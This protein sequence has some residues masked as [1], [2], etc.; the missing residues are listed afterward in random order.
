MKN[1]AQASRGHTVPRLNCRYGKD[2]A[3]KFRCCLTRKIDQA[4]FFKFCGEVTAYLEGVARTLSKKSG[5][6]NTQIKFYLGKEG[7]TEL[8]PS[9]RVSAADNLEE[10]AILRQSLEAAW[11]EGRKQLGLTHL[12]E[13]EIA[14]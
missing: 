12:E 6:A 7:T 9:V 1:K 2:N 11:V 3:R 4:E 14:A 10:M 8:V 13:G 5:P